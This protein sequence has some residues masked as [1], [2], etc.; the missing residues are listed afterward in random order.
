[1]IIAHL[2]RTRG[3]KGEIAA[4][5][6]SDHPERVKRVFVNGSELNVERI[7]RHDQKLIFK[8]AGIDSISD[9]ERFENCDAC[10]P[11]KE[12]APLAEGEY[13]QSDLVGCTVVDVTTGKTLG[14]VTDWQEYGGP[15][16]I[17]VTAPDGREILIPFALSICKEVDLAARM[18][19][20]ELPEGLAELDKA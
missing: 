10:I 12:R 13:Y 4:I 6:L 15:P 1:M 18:V 16:L 2:T 11:L 9:A 3:N 20:V 8:F 19:R 5:P 7:W 14:T 17:E